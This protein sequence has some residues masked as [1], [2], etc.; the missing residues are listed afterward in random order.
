MIYTIEMLCDDGETVVFDL[1][2][3]S[4]QDAEDQALSYA[5]E[6]QLKP[7]SEAEFLA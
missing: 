7:T 1:M 4:R 6:L 5:Q 2:A 3:A